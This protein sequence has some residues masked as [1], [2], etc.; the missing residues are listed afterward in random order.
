MEPAGIFK[1]HPSTYQI[2]VDRM[3]TPPARICFVST[4]GWD[5]AGA[6]SFGFRVVWLNRF[7]RVR[8]RLPAG[9]EAEIA[10]LDALPDLLGA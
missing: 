7:R 10:G 6:A 8:E 2:A 1:P 3:G 4:N 5:A 9:P